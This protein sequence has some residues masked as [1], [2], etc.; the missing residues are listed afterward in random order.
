[1]HAR[2][3]KRKRAKLN[4]L[5]RVRKK[6]VDI[7]PLNE[8]S[9]ELPA[10]KREFV[11][12]RCSSLTKNGT[13][14]KLHTLKGTKCWMHLMKEDNLRV[15]KSNLFPDNTKGN[16]NFGLFSG[17]KPFSKNQK[18]VP[19]SGLESSIPIQGD[20]ILQTCENKWKDSYQSNNLAGFAN[21]CRKADKTAKKCKGN[22]LKF[23]ENRRNITVNFVS[24]KNI[25]PSEELYVPYGR[26]YWKPL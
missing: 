16:K 17:K 1:M 4:P 6:I 23:S 24:T 14:C 11:S 22:N 7:E 3:K 12:N 10:N 20:Y 18:I 8:P 25:Q 9:T 19:Y 2:I 5:R 15:K 13:R 26:D 21:E